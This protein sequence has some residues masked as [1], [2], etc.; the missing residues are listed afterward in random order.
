MSGLA[1]WVYLLRGRLYQPLD[2]DQPKQLR[3]LIGNGHAR[4]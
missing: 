3:E 1:W 4:C 2:D